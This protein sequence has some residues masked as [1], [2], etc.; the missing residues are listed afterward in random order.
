[1]NRR[2]SLKAIG[3]STISTGVLLG[4]CKTGADKSSAA[5]VS[6][7]D[8][9]G[10]DTTGLQE[11]EK[12]RLREL[13]KQGAFF[14]DHERL[15]LIALGD[16]IIPKDEVSGSASDAKVIDFLDFIVK[17]IPEHQVPLRGGLKWLDLQCLN[18]YG[19]SFVGSSNSQQLEILEEIAYPEKVKPEMHQGAVFF[20]R[21]RDLV[22]TG[23]YTSQIGIKDI[24]YVGNVPGKWDGVPADVLAQ[25]NLKPVNY[26]V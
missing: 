2:Q 8:L 3:I 4:A 21:L 16:L 20:D 19:H 23:F 26:G 22:A 15:T 13:N 11:F 7:D 25:Y 18:R 12:E 17:D 14:N 24:G 1:M 10:A 6:E 5:V 9:G